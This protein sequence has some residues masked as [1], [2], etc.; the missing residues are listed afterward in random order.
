[1][2]F[3]HIDIGQPESKIDYLADSSLLL[4]CINVL[5]VIPQQFLARLQ[6]CNESV[7]GGGRKLAGIDLAC[8]FEK[9]SR[10]PPGGYN[11]GINEED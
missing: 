11:M 7:A 9:R 6:R 4:E 8:K 5:G 3:W 1:M 10:I 2:V